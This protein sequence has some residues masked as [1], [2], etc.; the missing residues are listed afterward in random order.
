VFGLAERTSCPIEPGEYVLT[1][2]RHA[3]RR[4]SEVPLVYL[5]AC[6]YG[7]GSAIPSRAH[8]L[9]ASDVRMMRLYLEQSSPGPLA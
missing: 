7:K 5:R 2:G 9:W 6:A 3:G 4:V 8:I 1:R